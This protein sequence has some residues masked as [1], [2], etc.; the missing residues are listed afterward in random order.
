MRLDLPPLQLLQWGQIDQDDEGALVCWRP[1]GK[2][3]RLPAAVWEVV[4]AYLE[5]SG[6]LEGI[7]P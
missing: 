7:Q 1:N 2:P 5:L 4:Q 6:R 3:V